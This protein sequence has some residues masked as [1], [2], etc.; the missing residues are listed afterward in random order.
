MGETP[1]N[2]FEY[3]R[4]LLTFA[5]DNIPKEK[6][7]VTIWNIFQ[8]YFSILF[9]TGDTIVYTCHRWYEAAWKGEAGCRSCQCQVEIL[10]NL[11]L[12][13]FYTKLNWKCSR[14]GIRENF[15]FYFPEGHLE[16]ISGKQEGIYQVLIWRYSEYE[17][18]M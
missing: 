4:P 1:D 16:I 8:K 14:K 9:K 7:K 3:L 6:H 15:Q 10:Q 11:L 18:Q 12:K 13:I 17:I 5:S 2:A